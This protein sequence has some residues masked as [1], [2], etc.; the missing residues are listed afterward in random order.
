MK[1]VPVS[2]FKPASLTRSWQSI[3]H[4]TLPLIATPSSDKK[5]R[6]YSL[7]DFG[8]HST[9]EK[10][11]KRSIRCVSWKP[12]QPNNTI[13]LATG[14]FDHTAGLWRRDEAA[15][16][17]EK[18]RAET[19]FTGNG[20][21]DEEEE[22]QDWEFNLV[23][24]GHDAEIKSVAYS[25]SGQ[26]LATCSRDKSVWIWE[27]IGADGEDEW[28]TIAVLQDHDGDVKSVSWCPDNRNGELLASASYD[29]TV[30]L[31]REDSEGEWECVAVLRGHGGTVWGLDWEPFLKNVAGGEGDGD[32]PPATKPL[33]LL[34][35]SSDATIRVWRR[36]LPEDQQQSPPPR[37]GVPSTMRSSSTE[38]TWICEATLPS[39]HDRA[40]YSVSWS[41]I[42]SRVV[43]TGSD[44]RVVVYEERPRP[45]SLA[46][47]LPNGH[48]D[49]GPAPPDQDQAQAQAQEPEPAAEWHV[50]ATLPLGHGPYEI[51]HAVWCR[52]FDH[53]GD[54][55]GGGKGEEEEMIVTT[56]DDGSV[57]AWAVVEE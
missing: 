55:S 45:R 18:L 37:N 46:R 25:P 16:R 54:G 29:D 44:S 13:S 41:K 24:E 10:G 39:A 34:T 20:E 49:P 50:L 35:C 19:D 2:S 47:S 12:N 8:L 52:R 1:I 23:L 53:R 3:P 38:Q 31:W 42:S 40:I 7:Q 56:G 26:Y 27:E 33:R 28:E 22:M 36:V 32:S 43:S 11:H 6:V 30:R 48:S 4:P 21:D 17:A 5:V 15:A 9:L 51:N 14:S 57:K